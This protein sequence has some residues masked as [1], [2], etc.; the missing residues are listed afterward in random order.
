MSGW[1]LNHL[2]CSTSWEQSWCTWVGSTLGIMSPTGLPRSCKSIILS[3]SQPGAVHWEAKVE[4]DGF[5]LQTRP[6]NKSLSVRSVS[7][8]EVSLIEQQCSKLCLL[9]KVLGESG[10]C[11]HAFLREGISRPWDLM[12]VLKAAEKI[13]IAMQC[14]GGQKWSSNTKSNYFQIHSFRN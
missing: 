4:T 1:I 5:T 9:L 8:W 6:W 13:L 11:I 3:F 2:L 12:L 14:S 7:L 10:P